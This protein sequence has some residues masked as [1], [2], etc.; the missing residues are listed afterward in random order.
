[1]RSTDHGPHLRHGWGHDYSLHM[2]DVVARPATTAADIPRFTVD[3]SAADVA[4]ALTTAGV[5]I[6][7]RLVPEPLVETLFVEM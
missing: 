4:A 3:A 6:I 2:A 7:E 1:M 5:A